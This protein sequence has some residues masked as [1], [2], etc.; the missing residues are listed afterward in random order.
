MNE[1]TQYYFNK[2]YYFDREQFVNTF[3]KVFT[4]DE[5]LKIQVACQEQRCFDDFLLY[6]NDDEYYIINLETG[7]IIRWYKH[8]GRCNG[9]NQANFGISDL[10]EL[11]EQLKESLESW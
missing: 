6:Y 10:I 2:E 3:H 8:L 9:V 7:I 4:T 11:L 1:T 5:I